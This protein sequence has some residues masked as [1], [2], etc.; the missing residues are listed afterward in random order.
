MSPSIFATF[1]FWQIRELVELI[2]AL[3]QV[4][5]HV[6]R[7]EVRE[8][9]ESIERRDDVV[10]DPQFL[11]R[12][13]DVVEFLD[14]LDLVAAERQNVQFLH[15]RQWNQAINAVCRKRQVPVFKQEKHSNTR[16][17]EMWREHSQISKDVLAVLECVER[18]IQL[19]D[20]RHLAVELDH[21]RFFCGHVVFRFLC[22]MFA[23]ESVCG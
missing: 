20:R 11:Q 10:R 2:S 14:F 4:V 5:R 21:R 3:D 6:Q 17:S 16:L 23:S 9:R 22:I 15:P 7:R 8:S 19:R 13:R 1:G 18:V 12:V